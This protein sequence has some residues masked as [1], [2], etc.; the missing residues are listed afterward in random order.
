M[1]KM[2]D[3]LVNQLKSKGK[4]T[5]VEDFV[6]FCRRVVEYQDQKD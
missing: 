4:D 5:S 6:E 2:L 3:R 1:P